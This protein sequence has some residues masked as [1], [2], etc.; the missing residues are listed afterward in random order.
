T[1]AASELELLTHS[2]YAARDVSGLDSPVLIL[3]LP[4]GGIE[5]DVDELHPTDLAAKVCRISEEEL[6]G[7]IK[8]ARVY[9]PSST[10]GDPTTLNAEGFESL[11]A[12]GV[13]SL[14]SIPVGLSRDRSSSGGALLVVCERAVRVDAET[15]NLLSLLAAQAWSS[16]ERIQTLHELR[17]LA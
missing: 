1:T 15:V 16:L 5:V 17:Q 3:N 2:L 12:L 6:R 13:R 11:T 9:G 14:I 8:R 10:I 4:D 7:F